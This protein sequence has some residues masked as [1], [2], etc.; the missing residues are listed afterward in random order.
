[1]A[2]G[3]PPADGA[4]PAAPAEGAAPAPA[5]GGAS[6]AAQLPAG[7]QQD[8]SIGFVTKTY[9]N[10]VQDIQQAAEG[11]RQRAL[12]LQQDGPAQLQQ[13]QSQI[14][15]QTQE[16]VQALQE[17][18]SPIGL[19]TSSVVEIFGWS[20][21]LL[22]S[23][24]LSGLVGGYVLSPIFGIFI[25]RMGAA[26]LASLVLPGVA[27]YQLNGKDGNTAETRFQLLLLSLAQGVLMGH[28]V[29]Y[30]YL[31]GQPI[32]FVTPLVIAFA[33]PL[34]AGQVGTAHAPLLGGAVGAAFAVQFALG[35]ISG[36]LSLGYLLLS[37]LYS[38]SSAGLLQIAF[39]NLNA[40][41]RIHLYQILLVGSFLFS[42][43]LVFGLFGSSEP[44][45][46]S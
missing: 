32:G 38:A 14:Q 2:D 19:P 35:L 23:A 37:A 18:K 10:Y 34:I 4:A 30:T 26:I 33:Y 31:S 36:S 3:Q 29:A 46:S 28:A 8:A 15:P 9:A 39:K 44:P 45:Q 21:I 16:L 24:G 17:I 1:M 40:P 13:L 5:E 11:L 6:P 25:G 43:A 12:A 7:G 22:L 20:S 27:A 41:N 42:K